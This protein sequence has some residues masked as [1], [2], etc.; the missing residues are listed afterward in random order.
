M[1]FELDV[2]YITLTGSRENVV[3]LLNAAICNAGS[4]DTIAPGDDIEAVNRKIKPAAGD[5]L[6]VSL[7]DL[8][9]PAAL[10]DSRL[11]A[12]QEAYFLK[13]KREDASKCTCD[14]TI[15][16]TKVS[17][18][19]CGCTIDFEM[20]DY[21]DVPNDWMGQDW[22][23]IARIYS[24]QV[25]VTSFVYAKWMIN[26]LSDVTVYKSLGSG[27]EGSDG[28]EE[29]HIEPQLDFS[30]CEQAFDELIQLDP[31]YRGVKIKHYEEAIEYLNY[32]IDQEKKNLEGNPSE[33]TPSDGPVI[34]PPN[35]PA[36][37]DEP[38]F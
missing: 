23:E 26:S 29:R 2:T 11:Q 36:S 4:G 16:L 38:P 21:P 1:S 18:A 31:R 33:E 24:C 14:K 5:G 6:H 30:S 9:D 32:L 8:L 17:E 15:E 19:E 3:R 34:L 28:V 25:V 22:G 12:K 35:P 10:R 7:T 37:D 13:Y 20:Y 27:D